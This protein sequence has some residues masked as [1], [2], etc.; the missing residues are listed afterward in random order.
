MSP[1][2]AA[3]IK[4]INAKQLDLGEAGSWHDQ[5]KDSAYIY[6]GGLPFQLTEGDVITIFSQQ[7][8]PPHKKVD[9]S[10]PRDPATQ[11]PRGFAFLMYADQRST[12]LAVDNLGGAKVLERTLRVDHVLNYKQLERDEETGKM[13]ERE[14]QSLAAHPDRHWAPPKAD[15]DDEAASDSDSSHPSIDPDDPMRDYLIQQARAKGKK[16]SKSSKSKHEGES[17]EERRKRREEKRRIKDE[18]A[19]RKEGKRRGEDT[20]TRRSEKEGRE[21]RDDA[22]RG[23]RRIEDGHRSSREEDKRRRAE[24]YSDR[25]RDRDRERGAGRARDGY[26]DGSRRRRDDDRERDRDR[27]AYDDRRR[28]REDDDED[29]AY[30][31]RRDGPSRSSAFADLEKAVGMR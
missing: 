16:S 4:R 14:Q 21:R 5:Y 10:M 1:G 28:R 6:V 22:G 19:R 26:G 27:G 2:T 8:T 3:E 7:V 31:R 11:K 13:K 15:T 29:D 25:G 23:E 17:K 9:I 18:R 20:S 12:V 24:P 30:R